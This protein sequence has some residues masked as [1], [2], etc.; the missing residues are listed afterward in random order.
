MDS[1]RRSSAE[2]GNLVLAGVSFGVSQSSNGLSDRTCYALGAAARRMTYLPV[3]MS[4]QSPP[5]HVS[6]VA[7]LSISYSDSQVT[8]N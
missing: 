4:A 7:D 3:M 1:N 2:F 6:L 8:S 5:A